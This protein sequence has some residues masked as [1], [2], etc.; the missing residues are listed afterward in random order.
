MLLS[1]QNLIFLQLPGFWIL[2][3]MYFEQNAVV[4]ELDLFL[5]SYGMVG[6][7]WGVNSPTFSSFESSL[8]F[9]PVMVLQDL[10]Q[11]L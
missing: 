9:M 4:W 10:Y 2:S 8:H 5:S 6:L 3:V 7:G 11:I 1:L